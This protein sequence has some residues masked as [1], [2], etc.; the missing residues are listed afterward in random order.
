MKQLFKTIIFN[1][2][3]RVLSSVLLI[4]LICSCTD[5][6]EDFNRNPGEPTLDE[7]TEGHYLTKLQFPTLINY[8]FPVQENNYQHCENFIGGVYGRYFNITK[9]EWKNHFQTFN[10]ID[11]WLYIPIEDAYKYTARSFFEVEKIAK[12][13]EQFHH[14]YNFA[15][16]L[17]VTAFQRLTDMY[18]PLPYTKLSPGNLSAEYDDQETIYRKMFEELDEAISFLTSF[19]KENPDYKGIS[20]IYD[21]IYSNDYKKWVIYANT[22]KLRMAM[23]IRYAEPELAKEKA[24]SAVNHEYGVM[25][26][27]TD[28]A[29]NNLFLPS[30]LHKVAV[31]WN[32]SR[33]CAD[34]I[35]YLT[36]YDDGMRLEKYFTGLG[37]WED[38]YVGLRSGINIA[39]QGIAQKMYSTAKINSETPQLIMA[40]TEAYFLRAEG[41][42][43]GWNMGGS[44]KDLYEA[45]IRTSFEQWDINDAS[46]IQSY[47]ENNS[48]TPDDYIIQYDERLDE[49]VNYNVKNESKATIKWDDKADFEVKLEKII[50]QKWIA[51]FP[52]G[53]EAW[54]EHRRTG[55]PKF[56]PVLLNLSGDP[57]LS[58]GT[59]SRIPYPSIEKNKE[60]TYSKALEYLGGEDNYSTRLWWDKKPNK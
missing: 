45:G 57:K 1:V 32:D 3:Y 19:D 46:Y 20:D 23:R 59:A 43:L 51:M 53:Q 39:S 41:A 14:L 25:T 10:C 35:C 21:A 55:Y 28:N 4:T 54:S 40:A 49:N 6:F 37:Y 2:N 47:I 26:S 11:D 18:G 38:H 7:L 12:D 42:L 16:I 48:S 17:K 13:Q 31:E 8:A 27:N 60:E 30:G 56:F 58:K 44:A 5:K 34:I 15:K 36:G 29:Y 33:A 22:L 52:I 50:T 9:S 24:E